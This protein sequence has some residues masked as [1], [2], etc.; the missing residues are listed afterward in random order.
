[1]FHP[2]LT[3]PIFFGALNVL[4]LSK[5][6]A[7]FLFNHPFEPF[8]TCLS[9][10][11]SICQPF[12][13]QKKVVPN[14]FPEQE[15]PLRSSLGATGAG[16]DS[17]GGWAELPV[18]NLNERLRFPLFCQK[19]RLKK[20]KKK[21]RRPW[22]SWFRFW[23]I[24]WRCGPWQFF[25]W[26]WW[27]EQLG[28]FGWKESFH[29]MDDMLRDPA[30]AKVGGL[31]EVFWWM[32]SAWIGKRSHNRARREQLNYR[33]AMKNHEKPMLQELARNVGKVPAGAVEACFHGALTVHTVHTLIS[34]NGPETDVVVK[35]RV[36]NSYDLFAELISNKKISTNPCFTNGS[37]RMFGTCSVCWNELPGP[38]KTALR[39]VAETTAK[40]PVEAAVKNSFCCS[41][42][43]PN[44]SQLQGDN[45]IVIVYFLPQAILKRLSSCHKMPQSNFEA[46]FCWKPDMFPPRK[47][48]ATAADQGEMKDMCV[49]LQKWLA[50]ISIV[51]S[52][53]SLFF[54]YDTTYI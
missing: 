41:N 8:R 9:D 32:A 12:F 16:G 15:A 49:K 2:I 30:F 19:K 50:E 29:K 22:F 45:R 54:D 11:S 5:N 26:C 47:G 24:E 52:C 40:P 21:L 51:F 48:Q 3:H 43:Y 39:D 20:S 13:N 25:S 34:R 18:V 14:S 1:M 53:F 4:E 46:D 17:Q 28:F 33:K 27:S 37:I 36:Q 6:L 7:P 31:I 42:S 44:I 10:E 38:S 35:R 23:F